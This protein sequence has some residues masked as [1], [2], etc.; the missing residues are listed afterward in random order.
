MKNG[1]HAMYWRMWWRSW[2][3]EPS[4]DRDRRD[5]HEAD[6]HRG[7][8]HRAQEPTQAPRDAVEHDRAAVRAR[9]LERE[10]AEQ[11]SEQGV[12]QRPEEPEPFGG[13]HDRTVAQ[14]AQGPGVS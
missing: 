2:D 5:D 11:K 4:L 7:A 8:M 12:R 9:G 14:A 3:Q 6:G 13:A 10:P 1:P